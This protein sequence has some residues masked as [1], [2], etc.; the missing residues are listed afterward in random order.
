MSWTVCLISFEDLKVAIKRSSVCVA[1]KILDSHTEP[2]NTLS[3]SYLLLKGP[4]ILFCKVP[5]II[6]K[7]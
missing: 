6:N 5:L 3:Q 7:E 4:L 1:L 2:V